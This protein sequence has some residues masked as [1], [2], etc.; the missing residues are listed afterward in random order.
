MDSLIGC[1]RKP[2]AKAIANRA[3]PSLV[4]TSLTLTG[5]TIPAFAHAES[6]KI[7]EVFV[8]AS[9]RE[10]NLQNVPINV[11]AIT[12][13]QIQN[14]RL[15]DIVKIAQYTPGLHSVEAGPRN[16]T[17]SLIGRGLNTTSVS[18]SSGASTFAIYYGDV[19]YYVDVHPADIERVE[20]LLGPQGTLY[21]AGTLAGA[22]RYI[23][24]YADPSEFSFE[25]RGNTYSYSE[26]NDLGGDI[27]F[28]ANVPIAPDV[29]AARISV[30][31][32]ADPGFIDNNFIVREP[33]I[34]DPEP[35]FSN[36]EQVRENL[37]QVEDNNGERQD[38]L[39]FNL[40]FQA[41][42]R[43]TVDAWYLNQQT[44]A[45][46]GQLTHREAFNTDDYESA[47]RYE[48]PVEFEDES[49]SFN[50]NADLSVADLSIIASNVDSK[51]QGQ[52]DQT[53]FL[54][55]LGY[56]YEFFP[57][58]SGNA[59]PDTESDSDIRELRLVSKHPGPVSWVYGVF[60][61]ETR[62]ES[63][64]RE[65][66]PNYDDFLVDIGVG[67]QTRPDSLEYI[68]A[69][70]TNLL[71][72]ATY[73]EVGIDITP[74]LNITAGYRNY[75]FEV[76]NISTFDLPLSRTVF[77]GDDPD[78]ILLEFDENQR[79]DGKFD[80]DLFKL[81]I[82]SQIAQNHLLYFTFSQGYRVGGANNEPLCTEED[83]E[84]EEQVVCALPNEKI[85]KPDLIDNY[86][87]GYKFNLFDNRIRTNI[88]A[89]YIDWTDIQVGSNTVNGGSPITVNGGEA[90]SS[91]LEL[92]SQISLSNWDLQLT[93]AFTEAELTKEAPNIIA[94]DSTL[95]SDQLNSG[96]FDSTIIVDEGARLPGSAKHR[97]SINLTYHRSLT[98]DLDLSV[99]YGIVFTT[100]VANVLGGSSNA[101]FERIEQRTINEDTG[102]ETLTVTEA[103]ID[104]GGE[105]I[106]GYSIHHLA[107]TFASDHWRVQ[108]YIDNLWDKHYVTGTAGTRRFLSSETGNGVTFPQGSPNPDHTDRTY[109][110]FV[111]TPRTIG[112]RVEYNF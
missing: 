44:F 56:G 108:A 51:L 48:E 18:S 86:E 4:T 45:E 40:R 7:E 61:Q 95:S 62:S 3:L 38:S 47:Y 71:E 54:L 100:D 104:F 84:S 11:S 13:T 1:N 30:D 88:A 6:Q 106:D 25:V 63:V 77:G 64:T 39:R 20:V 24:K 89:Y 10:E 21:G 96:E 111:G 76:D 91:G 35:D 60:Y 16:P 27:G 41:S 49:I 22:V 37:R 93:Y 43:V 57:N 112:L 55:N 66:T 109:A 15:D 74:W 75:T 9:R 65:F 12:D 23:P 32:T 97:G 99:N 72:T 83:L 94:A 58:F 103:D 50:V 26:G 107:A 82:S 59:T 67:L 73:T 14:L 102:E 79:E 42:E 46:G 69:S 105:E 5:L 53:D 70:N 101:I 110:E 68:A 98:R 33:G 17:P 87:I 8:T 80:G 90:Y 52:F 85:V 2:L 31:R 36:R 19:P 81:N 28:S 34:S 29:L 92:S 78:S